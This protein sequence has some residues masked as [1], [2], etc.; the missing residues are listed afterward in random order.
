MKEV[1]AKKAEA[2]ANISSEIQKSESYVIVEYRGL[3]VAQMT[4]LRRDLAK[5]GG[6]LTVYKNNLVERAAKENGYD[7]DDF[8]AGPNAFVSATEDP[9]GVPSLLYKFAK[10]NPS[11][12]IKGGIVEKKVVGAEEMAAVSKL[13]TKPT[14]I[15]MLLGCLQS[16]ITKF[17]Y[18]AKIIKSRNY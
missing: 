11:L 18:V 6:K 12:V 9:V 16:P 5:I 15:A 10:K 2:V 1:L 13:P 14:L 17:A 4:T 7:L 8:L 3:T